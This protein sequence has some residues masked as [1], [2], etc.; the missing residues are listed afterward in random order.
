[1]LKLEGMSQGDI[2]ERLNA[3]GVLCPMEYKLSLGMKVQTNFR[4]NRK[5]VWS[6]SSVSRI[7]TKLRTTDFIRCTR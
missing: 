1:M 6:W 5:A 3:Q 4:A 2:A 7:L